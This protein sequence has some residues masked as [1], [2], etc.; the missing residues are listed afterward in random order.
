[1]TAIYEKGREGF[2]DGTI[3]WDT[4]TMKA[5]LLDLNTADT[6]IKQ[7]TAASNATPIVITS[8]SHGFANGDILF[9]D[10]V[11]GN[12]AANG[13][14]KAANVAT[15]TFELT[16]L[17]GTNVVGFA[18]YTSGGYAVNLGPSAS[19]DNWDDFDGALVGAAVT[20]T[21]PTVT[22]G[23]AGSATPVTFTSVSGA[24]VEAVAVYKDT[25]TPSTSRMASF[26]AG[27][28]N[29]IV[30]ADAAGS[31]T[32]IWVLPLEGPI[33]S[34]VVLTFSNGKQATLS[35]PAAEGA[36][37]LT[38]SALANAIA[39]PNQALAPVTGAGLP[40]TP[41]GNNITMT[42]LSSA[43]KYFKL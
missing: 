7:I 6:G 34:G 33:A 42:L 2:L 15:N 19:G 35:A 38:V 12:L 20:L 40:L 4:S 25:G 17:D 8:N 36:I 32:T 9:I 28:I 37:S 3:D 41:N 26:H 5:A 18:A 31:A 23:V 39:A 22:Q 13:I 24:T 30:A 10:G 21:S 11:G 27:K 16:R 29:V 1:M 43:N 14:Y